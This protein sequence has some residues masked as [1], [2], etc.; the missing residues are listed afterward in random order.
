MQILSI[1][2]KKVT[3]YFFLIAILFLCFS[4]FSCDNKMHLYDGVWKIESAN[5]V[6][7]LLDMGLVVKLVVDTTEREMELWTYID[8]EG[9]L[10]NT[11][12]L[13]SFNFDSF[14]F[15]LPDL[16]PSRKGHVIRGT[17]TLIGNRLHYQVYST[18]CDWVFI[19]E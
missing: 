9:T 17:I 19:K 13:T 10:Q 18:Q 4:S 15:E 1:S 14:S 2:N 11:G 3:S 6:Q 8:G 7:N 5:D 16:E 12:K